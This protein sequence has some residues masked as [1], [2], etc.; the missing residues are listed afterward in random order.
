MNS[1][2]CGHLELMW[3]IALSCPFCGH[4]NSATFQYNLSNFYSNHWYNHYPHFRFL[5]K[6]PLHS[7]L[8]SIHGVFHSISCNPITGIFNFFIQ[9]Q[10]SCNQLQIFLPIVIV[11]QLCASRS[12]LFCPSQALLRKPKNTQM[13]VKGKEIK[14]SCQATSIPADR[15]P[16]MGKR[17]TMNLLLLGAIGLPTATMLYP[18]TYF[19]V[20]PG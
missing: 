1:E 7:L 20:P 2:V 12:A 13:G 6:F 14:I 4:Q 18:Y 8:W 3:L 16:D 5:R 9:L 17:K 15:V 10:W 11:F 19:F